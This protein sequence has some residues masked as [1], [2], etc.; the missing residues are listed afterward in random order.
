MPT[1]PISL[2]VMTYNE[3]KHIARCLDSVPFASEKLVIDSGSTDDTVAIA[4]A[5][6]ARVVH[7]DWLGFGPQRNFATTQCSN[8]WILALDADEYLSL[9][10]AAELQVRLPELMASELSAVFLR[11]STI[12]MG[13]RMRWYLPSVGEKMARLYHRER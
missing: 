1:F 10:L 11:R 13:A 2:V 8:D 3:A 7:Q 4:Q 5:H 12:Y 9:E 6:G